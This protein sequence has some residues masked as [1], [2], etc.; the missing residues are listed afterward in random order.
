MKPKMFT[1]EQVASMC[2]V[3]TWK[4]L[5]AKREKRFDS[6]VD[7]WGMTYIWTLPS[8]EN[9]RRYFEARRKGKP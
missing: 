1:T 7:L 6:D 2:R 9:A 3:P 4:L 5:R 8:A